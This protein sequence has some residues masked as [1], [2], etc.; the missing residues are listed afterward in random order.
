M[1]LPSLSDY[2]ICYFGRIVKSFLQVS[3][4]LLRG[5]SRGIFINLDMLSITNSEVNVKSFLR[6][7]SSGPL[8]AAPSQRPP[9]LEAPLREASEISGM[10]FAKGRLV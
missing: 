6:P 9:Y 3:L 2:S 7:P 8:S 1:S 5:I 10:V 4:R